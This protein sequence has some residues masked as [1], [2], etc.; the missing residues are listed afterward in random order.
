MRRRD[1]LLGALSCATWASI[2]PARAHAEEP[3]QGPV[4]LIVPDLPGSESGILA[5]ALRPALERVL[6]R[7]TLVDFRPGAGGVVGLIDGAH[8]PADGTGLTLLTPAITEAPWLTKR[9]DCTPDDFA[10]L[11]RLTFMPVVLCVRTAGPYS[12]LPELVADMRARPGQVT[13]ASVSGW[14][15][16]EFAQA[17]FLAR[18]GLSAQLVSGPQAPDERLAA[19]RRGD[20][21]FTFAA[22]RDVLTDPARGDLR[23]LALTG[24]ARAP[25][26]PEVPCFRE[27]GIDLAI[28]EWRALAVPAATPASVREPAMLALKAT[29]A[30]AEFTAELA[31]LGLRANWLGPDETRAA[32]QAEYRAAGALFASLGINI[33]PRAIGLAATE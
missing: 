5:R 11:G 32:L 2:L 13:A 20:I 33:R 15:S 23:L 3:Q 6:V 10:V 12:R 25:D 1:V 18:S 31:S 29:L 9:M 8:G 30:S 27:Q 19:L 28:G 17:L 4:S 21:D 16:A 22:A 14:A 7:E 26:L 24:P